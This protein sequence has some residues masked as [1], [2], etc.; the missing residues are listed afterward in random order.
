MKQAR[1]RA[2]AENR[3]VKI[4][5]GLDVAGNSGAAV[6][7]YVFDAGNS[8]AEK[9]VQVMYSGFSR[10]L[11]LTKND[12]SK[13]PNTLNFKSRGTVGASTIYFCSAGY[14]KRIVVNGIGRAYLCDSNST[15]TACQQA[16]VCL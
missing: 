5:F 16:Y 2:L 9:K 8:G 13:K 11:R 4:Q 6:N 12:P 3:T 15:S 14:S 7:A 10:N 1:T